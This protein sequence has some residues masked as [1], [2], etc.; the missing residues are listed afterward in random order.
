MGTSSKLVEYVILFLAAFVY[1]PRFIWHW[2]H[3]TVRIYHF[4]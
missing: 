3:C 1:W 2:Q 4:N